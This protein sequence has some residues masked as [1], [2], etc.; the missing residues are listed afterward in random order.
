MQLFLGSGLEGHHHQS[1]MVDKM[2]GVG[3]KRLYWC[4][5]FS[6][7]SELAV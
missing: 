3:E 1:K 5:P 7:K 2:A 4:N 6:D